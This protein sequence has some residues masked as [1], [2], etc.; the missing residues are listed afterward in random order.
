MKANQLP[1]GSRHAEA[2]EAELAEAI[3]SK[4]TYSLGK[5][6]RS[7]TD[8]DWYQ[9]TALAVRDRVVDVW[10]QSR[11]ETNRLKKRRGYYLSI[12]F[13]I[14]RLLLDT[15]TNLRLV[16]PTRRALAGLGV[17]HERLRGGEP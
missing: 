4:L 8:N 17:D 2:L 5:S 6:F 1:L 12:E 7:A 3:K 10:M 14:G 13:L 11:R 16:E 9:A 15:L